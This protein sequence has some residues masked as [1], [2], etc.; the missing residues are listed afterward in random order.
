MNLIT[1]GISEEVYKLGDA[2]RTSYGIVA[3]DST[4]GDI[5]NIVAAAR[6]LSNDKSRVEELIR[7]CNQGSLSLEH[8]DEIIEDFISHWFI[9]KQIEKTKYIV[10]NTSAFAFLRMLFSEVLPFWTR[11]D[12]IVPKVC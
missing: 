3:Y 2:Y 10:P 7:R 9:K 6:D 12:L 11:R 5:F 4:E 1:Y 8:F